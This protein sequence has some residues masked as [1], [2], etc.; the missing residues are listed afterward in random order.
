M[1]PTICLN[2]IVKDEAHVIRRCLDSVR[3]FIDRWAIVDTGSTDGTQDIIREH[4]KDVPGELFE[5]PWKNFGH[6]RTEALELAR[7]QADYLF[8]IDADEILELPAGFTRQPLTK[9]A[10]SLLVEYGGVSYGRVCLVSARLTWRYVGVLHEYLEADSAYSQER[11]SGP[12]VIPHLEGGRGQGVS[13]AEKYA[14]DARI[15]E[16]A[17]RD[18]PENSRYVFY[19]AQSYRDA[20]QWKKA[21][22][23]YKRRAGMGGWAEEVWY[24]LFEMAKLSE[25]LQL[26]PSVIVARYLDAYDNRPQRAEPLV[27]LARFQRERSRFGIAHLFAARA[28]AMPRPEDILFVDIGTYEWRAI[29]EFAVASYWLGRYQDCA[30][31]C[32]QLLHGGRLPFEHRA[33]VTQNLNFAMTELGKASVAASSTTSETGE[34]GAARSANR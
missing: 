28:I 11:L 27:E 31:A 25:R 5:R 1:R 21:F 26:E 22:R 14:N 34:P 8:I 15:L 10:Y 7:G 13:T 18:E 16:N 19:L 12:K 9:D 23:N 6:N 32:E 20:G 3:P 33:R 4:F 2:M 17:L 29:D 24:S 30:Q